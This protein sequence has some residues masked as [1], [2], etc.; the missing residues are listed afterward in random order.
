MRICL[1]LI[2]DVVEEG[3]EMSS[4][5]LSRILPQSPRPMA[6]VGCLPNTENRL[7]RC[8]IM[9]A[10]LSSHQDLHMRMVTEQYLLGNSII[11]PRAF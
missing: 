8:F 7:L 3:K 9:V 10:F 6:H 1:S 4:Y 11:L 2:Y 5:G